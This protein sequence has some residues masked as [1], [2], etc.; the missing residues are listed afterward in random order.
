MTA[1]GNWT[2]ADMSK[3]S[4]EAGRMLA[5][6]FVSAAVQFIEKWKSLPNP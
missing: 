6:N 2:Q 5:E 3:A 1:S 4:A